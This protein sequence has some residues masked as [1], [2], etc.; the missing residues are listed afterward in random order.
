MNSEIS[1]VH[2]GQGETEGRADCS[3][4]VGGKVKSKNTYIRGLSWGPQD[5]QISAPAH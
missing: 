5:E 2:I 3:R 1:P 4:M